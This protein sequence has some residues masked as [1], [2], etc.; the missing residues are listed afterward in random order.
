MTFHPERF[1]SSYR[2]S[3]DTAPARA[4]AYLL[5]FV[6]HVPRNLA[7]CQGATCQQSE[8]TERTL[9]CRCK[10]SSAVS[11]ADGTLHLASQSRF[12]RLGICL[13]T[14]YCNPLWTCIRQKALRERGKLRGQARRRVPGSV[15]SFA[16]RVFEE[17]LPQ[18]LQCWW[19]VCRMFCSKVFLR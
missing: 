8:Q 17:N 18:S 5:F 4:W 2:I 1:C 13:P 3:H 14:C 15:Q 19:D 9:L 7:F 10:L 16:C 12:G 11:H 6:E